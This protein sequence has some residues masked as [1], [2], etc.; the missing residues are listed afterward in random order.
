[1][2]EN[3]NDQKA[4]NDGV[5]NQSDGSQN[6]QKKDGAPLE[7][8]TDKTAEKETEKVKPL[9]AEE[10]KEQEDRKHPHEVSV[11]VSSTNNNKSSI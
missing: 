8:S 7:K 2:T 3:Q 6:N 10:S 1:M 4:Q 5:K 9:P 11:P